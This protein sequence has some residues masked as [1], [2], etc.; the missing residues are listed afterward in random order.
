M[1]AI[2]RWPGWVVVGVAISGAVYATTLRGEVQEG[3]AQIHELK[4]RI[5]PLEQ[6]PRELDSL[7]IEQRHMSETLE[8]IRHLLVRPFRGPLAER[9]PIP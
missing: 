6:V 3:Q 4:D 5:R 8:E 2:I 1:W 9:R 7:R